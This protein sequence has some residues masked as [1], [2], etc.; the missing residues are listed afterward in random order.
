MNPEL[1]ERYLAKKAKKLGI[2]V[3]ELKAQGT[4]SPVSEPSSATSSASQATSYSQQ[5]TNSQ[6][7]Y[8]QRTIQDQIASENS[9]PL[10]KPY[11][12]MQAETVKSEVPSYIFGPSKINETSTNYN[13]YNNYNK[14]YSEFD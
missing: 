3:E 6:C 8:V 9:E 1:Y 4:S 7:Q 2:T 10:H 5:N 12:G 14:K 11:S 13:N